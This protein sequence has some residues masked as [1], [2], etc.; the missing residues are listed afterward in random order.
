MEMIRVFFWEYTLD[1][2]RMR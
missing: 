1:D 2:G